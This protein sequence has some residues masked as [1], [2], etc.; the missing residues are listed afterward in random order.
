MLAAVLYSR[1]WGACPKRR[2]QVVL[3]PTKSEDFFVKDTLT[4]DNTMTLYL[5]KEYGARWADVSSES[6]SIAMKV[7]SIDTGGGPVTMPGGE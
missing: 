7:V 3:T 2:T 6:E 1:G 4:A 5:S